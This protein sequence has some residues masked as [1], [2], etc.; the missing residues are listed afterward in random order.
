MKNKAAT[1]ADSTSAA[2]CNSQGFRHAPVAA[3]EQKNTSIVG[4]LTRGPM[5]PVL[6][7]LRPP[8]M[9][10]P[11]SLLERKQTFS[12]IDAHG[13]ATSTHI[14]PSGTLLLTMTKS[15]FCLGE[16]VLSSYLATERDRATLPGVTWAALLDCGVL[17]SERG[18]GGNRRSWLTWQLVAP[19]DVRPVCANRSHLSARPT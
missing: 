2:S 16:S 11:R 15:K 3:L 12:N 8:P 17:G 5:S 19:F 6:A 10:A 1:P 7:H 9:S 14:A 18:L 13:R 4:T